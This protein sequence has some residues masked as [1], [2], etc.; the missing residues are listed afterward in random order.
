MDGPEFR[1]LDEAQSQLLTLQIE[2]ERLLHSYR[3][4]SRRVRAVDKEIRAVELF[5]SK[6]ATQ[7]QQ[8]LA[9]TIDQSLSS[10]RSA[11]AALRDELATKIEEIDWAIHHRQL[12]DLVELQASIEAQK[13]ITESL[14]ESVRT[15][16]RSL[17]R[18]SQ[19]VVRLQREQA[20]CERNVD[21]YL[22]RQQEAYISADL[23][24]QKSISVR[25]LERATPPVEPSGL[26]PKMKIAVGLVAGVLAGMASAIGIEMLRGGRTRD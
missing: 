23:D 5:L 13:A 25:V 26:S 3:P 12:L 16:I 10:E 1:S 7:V 18:V 15:E 9:T 22:Q 4:D 17:D 2:R 21:T 8:S 11:R 19:E 20:T 24:R 6:R 14:R